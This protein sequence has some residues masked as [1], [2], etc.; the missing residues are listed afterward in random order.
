MDKICNST[1]LSRRAVL[2]TLATLPVLTELLYPNA[3]EAQAPAPPLASWNDGPGGSSLLQVSKGGQD[4]DGEE[5]GCEAAGDP[6]L[7]HSRAGR[8]RRR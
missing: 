6:A 2:S 4:F 7:G 5:G 8:Y 3:A 1:G